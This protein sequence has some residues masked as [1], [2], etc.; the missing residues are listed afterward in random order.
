M[1]RPRRQTDPG[2]GGR[3][4]CIIRALGLIGVSS[5]AKMD[6]VAMP[7]NLASRPEHGQDKIE[8]DPACWCSEAHPARISTAQIDRIVSVYNSGATI[9][10][11]AWQCQVSVETVR[12]H[13]HRRGVPVRSRVV[14]GAEQMPSIRALRAAGT[15]F[16]TMA[17]QYGCS[18][19]TVCNALQRNQPQAAEPELTVSHSGAA[20]H[21]GDAQH[22]SR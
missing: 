4:A 9:T 10:E 15:S 2:R 6:R 5:D 3:L 20:A 8:A 17:G 18:R 12:A 11:T 22:A 7:R 1:R 13:L 19:G 21:A 14:P 16:K